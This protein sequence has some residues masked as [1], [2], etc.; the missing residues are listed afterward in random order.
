M[1]TPLFCTNYI[2]LAKLSFRCVAPLPIFS[3]AVCGSAC[4]HSVLA[5]AFE[6]CNAAQITS[7]IERGKTLTF[8]TG[9]FGI[10]FYPDICR[11]FVEQEDVFIRRDLQSRLM[12]LRC[13]RRLVCNN[14]GRHA[15]IYFDFQLVHMPWGAIC[16][17]PALSG[18]SSGYGAFAMHRS[19]GLASALTPLCQNVGNADTNRRS[20]ASS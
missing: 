10:C 3:M 20:C 7:G 15:R 11:I 8:N 1:A 13:V 19:D 12:K 4:L 18:F 5:G 14:A 17:Y 2:E 6:L 9:F 16:R